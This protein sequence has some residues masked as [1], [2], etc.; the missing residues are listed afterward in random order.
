MVAD[1]TL[2]ITDEFLNGI[3]LFVIGF[4]FGVLFVAINL[5]SQER[6]S[7]KR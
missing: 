4:V 7:S 1:Y 5:N 6:K 2:R 3:S